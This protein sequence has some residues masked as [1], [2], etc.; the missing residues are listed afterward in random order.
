MPDSIYIPLSYYVES[1]WPD[2]LLGRP[3]DQ[4]LADI[5]FEPLQIT[6]VPQPGIRTGILLEQSIEL[7]IPGF[8]L[9][10]FVVAQANQD[11]LLLLE[12]TGNPSWSVQVA[13]MALAIRLR[14]DLFRPVKR[15]STNAGIRYELDT[16]KDFVD[17]LVARA[18][19]SLNAG[20]RF[21]AAI[22]QKISLPMCM[23]GNTGLIIGADDIKIDFDI[24]D[25]S[26]KVQEAF[27]LLPD[28][29]GLPAATMVTFSELEI[30]R[31]G[32]SGTVSLSIPLAYDEASNSFSY[33][34]NAG[35]PEPATLFGISGGIGR[36]ALTLEQ[37]QITASDITGSMIVPY[38]NEPVEIR[39]NINS[40]GDFVI[41]LTGLGDEDIILTK[42]ELLSLNI[43]SLAL[44][45]EG[46]TAS[47]VVNGGLTPLLMAA[48][49]LEW[50][51][52]E[53]TDLSIDNTGKFKLKEAWL[54]LKELATLDLWGFHFELNRIGLGYQEED[55]KL[56]LDLT[57]SLRLIEQIPVGLG[58]EGFRLT[59]PRD[60]FTQLAING[61]PT[62]DE[63]L[64]IADSLEVKFDG[65]YLFYGVPGAIEFEGLLEFIQDAQSV[66]FAGEM[67]LRVPA[68]GLAIEAGLKVGMNFASPPYPFLL[69][70]FAVEL[71]AGI[72]LA[73]SGLALKGAQGLF[74]LNMSPNRT[75]D[76]NWYYD[77][78]KRD[79]L[80]AHRTS[81]W[82]DERNA[83]ALGVGVTITTADGYVKGVR[84]LL[85]L[86]LPG[87]I[88]II[89]GR[90]L[91][92]DSLTSAEPPLRALA[93]IDGKEQIVQFNIEAEAALIEDMIDAYGM[94]EAFFDF[95]DLTN[96]HLYLGQDEPD[97][98]RIR[99]NVLKFK[100][101]F[102]FKA[103]A[104]LMVDMV[105]TQTLRSR[106]G[107]FVGFAPPSIKFEAIEITLEAVLEGRGEVTVLP[108]Q[109]SGELD[110]SATIALKAFGFGLQLGAA[111]GV[112]TE[113]PRPFKVDAEVTVSVEL[114]W[115]LDP[116]EERLQFSWASLN[117]PTITPPLLS[118]TAASPFARG[119]GALAIREQTTVEVQSVW[120][121][122]AENSPVVPLDTRPI[123]A[124]NHEMNDQARRQG[125]SPQPAFVRHPSGAA[126]TYDVSLMRF[127]PTLTTVRLYEH[128]K[129]EPWP[130]SLNDWKKVAA[131]RMAE[132]T[133]AV[134]RLPGVWMAEADPQAP[135]NP[136]TRRLHL[137]TKNPLLHAAAALGSGYNLPFDTSVR[138]RQAV[139]S[140]HAEQLLDLYPDLMQC[141][142]SEPQRI[143]VTFA[144]KAGTRLEPDVVWEHGGLRFTVRYHPASV[145]IERPQS[146]L[147]VRPCLVLQGYLDLRFP[148]PVREIRIRFCKLP[149]LAHPTPHPY[150]RM[151]RTA[152]SPQEQLEI[153]EEA[154]VNGIAPDFRACRYSVD[155]QVRVDNDDWIISAEQGFDC[156]S[157]LRLGDCAIAEVCYLSV[158]EVERALRAIAQCKINDG[159][160]RDPQN[161][162]R[163]GSYYRLEIETSVAGGLADT[164][165]PL[166][167]LYTPILE[168]LGFSD[169]AQPYHHVAF[170]Q[171]EGPPTNLAPYIKWS[172]PQ[173]QATRVFREDNFAIRFLRPNMREMYAHPPHQLELLILSAEGRPVSGYTTA[174]RKAR[175]ASL[176]HEEQIWREHRPAVGLDNAA[177]EADDV[178]EVR[179]V[180][181]KLEPNARYTLWVHNGAVK[182]PLFQ[183]D[184][185]TSAFDG[186][187]ELLE[188]GLVES[189]VGSGKHYAPINTIVNTPANDIAQAV[190]QAAADQAVAKLAYESWTWQRS[191][192]DY[193]FEALDREGLETHKLAL[194]EARAAHDAAFRA[195]AET[196]AQNLLYLPFAPH[197]ELY[198]LR[199]INDET[200]GL[201]LRSPESLDLRLAVQ[202]ENSTPTGEHVGR[203]TLQLKRKGHREQVD[204]QV[205]HDA[206]STQMLIVPTS[207]AHLLRGTY[208]LIFT[209]DR[210]H[211]DEAG[212]GDHRYDRP[213]E[214]RQNASAVEVVRLALTIE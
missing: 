184:F 192:I 9:V 12:L 214:Q 51:T 200:F 30:N 173:Q 129:G 213:V 157:M 82:R 139:G 110:L 208:Q 188:S 4:A 107:I 66:G 47:V 88:L 48:D 147:P 34:G 55:D 116:F 80:G 198:L 121:E 119:G 207:I 175:S 212:A 90:A 178:L 194:R 39:I 32:C 167:A 170:F 142:D 40:Q 97:D 85:V 84:G 191:Q 22:D 148:E 114:P 150:L 102:L 138:R 16:S 137:W 128:R 140:S 69:L 115:P 56:W 152:H 42:D 35:A 143:C 187:R 160:D 206:D 59:W 130:A 72:P 43:Q 202:N 162:L 126:K 111:G 189:E 89:E 57:G 182:A 10:R 177:A 8:D 153:V 118:V 62:L 76:Q 134:A 183:V 14:S 136:A 181:G 65:V 190:A 61:P 98:R 141:A 149:K 81:K 123:L 180:S 122:A 67:A 161:V 185:T 132:I 73:Q 13:D 151:Y 165:N 145:E 77:W 31:L 171:T 112:A 52:L 158:A 64:A 18:D 44:A 3:P 155:H 94:L 20:G 50:P 2:D 58:V 154:R 106:M 203:T 38:F 197:V 163:P 79:P 15:V 104:Y 204:I 36:F 93:V 70:T 210:N 96:W 91:I 68:T 201:W 25:P 71:P 127:T 86:A 101:S 209:Y 75:E 87:P 174:W 135:G 195:L 159:D 164:N 124:F 120:Q 95:K 54:D 146:G 63:A 196:V 17:I 156:L 49:G 24:A 45:R 109:F 33:T 103:D 78:Y 19:V 176:L 144:G 74:G 92:L 169:T 172:N 166:D 41:T 11:A 28:D 46:N 26:I 60:L 205:F 199:N 193:R 37:N 131:S 6:L 99:A 179:R 105:G 27:V 23:L 117:S 108:E 5:W 7:S 100:D 53:V 211:G 1:V 113:G 125:N 29:L 186:F 83:L 133:G 168:Q 21:V